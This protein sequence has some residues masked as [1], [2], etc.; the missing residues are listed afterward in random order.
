VTAA[1][2]GYLWT[3]FEFPF[4][5]VLPAAIGWYAVS[6]GAFGGRK[7]LFAALVGGVSFTAALLVGFAFALT[8]GSPI[9][10]SA[11]AGATLAAAV[12]GAL[13]GAVLSGLRGAAVV[14]AFSAGGMLAA[15]ALS[16]VLRALAPASVDVEG[17]AQYAFF[18]LM[19]GII[20]MVVGAAIGAGVGW[21]KTH[22][23]RR[24]DN[25]GLMPPRPH[26]A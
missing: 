5:V 16:G 19:I 24:A 10:L 7:A 15:T 20:G 4:A 11:W 13:T 12:A 3:F 18:A 8:D 1:V 6:R 17:P 23:G 25:G 14:A 26:A 2:A 21:L 22:E 9:A